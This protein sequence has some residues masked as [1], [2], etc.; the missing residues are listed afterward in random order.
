MGKLN[1]NKKELEKYCTENDIKF[2]VLFGSY[3]S[4]SFGK[5]SDL[6]AAVSIKSG[7]SI[8]ADLGIYSDIL[9]NLAKILDISEDKIDLTDLNRA[10]I[11]LRYEITSQG[12]LLFGDEDEFAQYQASAFRN[13]MDAKPLFAVEDFLVKKRQKMLEQTLD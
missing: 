10:N 6:D 12:R 9:E 13:Y 8:F 7:K 3:A 2:V 1:F 4:G 11:L 5:G